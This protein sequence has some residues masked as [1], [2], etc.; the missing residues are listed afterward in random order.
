MT[1]K[2]LTVILAACI[3]FGT[4]LTAFA[5][6]PFD[7]IFYA[8]TYPDV[9]AALGTD[10]NVLYNH[11]INCGRAE[12]RK[13]YENAV[14]GEEVE[15]MNTS[16][17][18]ASGVVPFE[19]LAH[20]KFLKDT[21]TK[22]EFKYLY[23]ALYDSVQYLSSSYSQY[24]YTEGIYVALQYRFLTG[25]V[26][27]SDSTEHYSNAC[28][29]LC[30]GAADCTGCTRTVGLFLDMAGIEWEPI[31]MT[32]SSGVNHMWCVATIDGQRYIVDP[33]TSV[34][35]PETVRNYHPASV[36]FQ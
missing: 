11:Y 12:G 17:A 8:N 22:D 15:R 36:Y 6:E 10:S 29:Y 18:A 2:I 28:G 27:Y 5:A 35:A 25:M 14:G 1:R 21:L 30:H 16:N 9:A 33:Y 32:Y 13:A 3:A 19:N 34:F 26:V 31:F 24:E 7:P 20:Y 23:D 4:S